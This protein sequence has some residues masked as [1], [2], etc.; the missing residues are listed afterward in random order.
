MSNVQRLERA[1]QMSWWSAL[2]TR[3]PGLSEGETIPSIALELGNIQAQQVSE[4]QRICGYPESDILPLPLPHILATPLHIAL[5]THPEFPLPAM[6]LVHVSN[7]IVQHR[8]IKAHET[9]TITCRCEGHRPHPRG[10]LVDL[11]TEIVSGNE[12]VWESQTTALSKSAPGGGTKQEQNPTAPMVVERS[13]N[14]RLPENLGRKYGV[15]S[16]D[17]NP[18]HLFAWSAKL[19]GFKRHI[20]HGMWLL[21]RAISELDADIGSGPVQVDIDFVRPVFLPGSVL[22]ESGRQGQDIGFAL[23]NPKNGKSHARGRVHP[24]GS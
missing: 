11:Q 18:I 17:K 4:Y 13:T 8:P 3:K 23:S 19:F 2:T 9:L 21:G 12:R 15:I 7:S 10:A 1:P 22:F 5:A 6:G 20:I 14:W 24:L 16:G